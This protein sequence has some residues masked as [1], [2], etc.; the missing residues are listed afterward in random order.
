MDMNMDMLKMLLGIGTEEEKQFA[1]GTFDYTTI[2][3]R[4]L[5]LLPIVD[6]HHSEHKLVEEENI[7]GYLITHS[8]A[9]KNIFI[10]RVA[11]QTPT[12]DGKKRV[13]SRTLKKWNVTDMVRNSGAMEKLN[14]MASENTE[15]LQQ[16]TQVIDIPHVLI[17]PKDE[18]KALPPKNK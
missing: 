6:D 18:E 9:K 7:V 2:L 11:I 3:T 4:F 16:F 17:N 12:I 13:I 15:L 8:T 14:E 1:N 10:R 5:K